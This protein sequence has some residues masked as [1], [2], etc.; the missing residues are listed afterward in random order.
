MQ[1]HWSQGQDSPKR[2]KNEI[3]KKLRQSAIFLVEQEFSGKSGK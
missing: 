3:D 1:D 2:S